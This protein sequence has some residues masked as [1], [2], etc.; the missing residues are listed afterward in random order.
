M[1]APKCKICGENH[2][3]NEPHI[4]DMANSSE[5][6]ANTM[7]NKGGDAGDR[8]GEHSESKPGMKVGGSASDKTTRG[9]Y[10]YRDPEKRREY[11]RE[12]MKKRRGR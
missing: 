1:K 10:R 2:W 6:M 8:L 4:W 12:Y 5:D 7:A 11:M 9:T 3:G